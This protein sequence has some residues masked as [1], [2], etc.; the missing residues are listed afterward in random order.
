MSLE[1]GCR[2]QKHLHFLRCA[3]S[4]LLV[5]YGDTMICHEI[6]LDQIAH[7]HAKRAVTVGNSA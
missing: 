3:H 7:I 5:A 6:K 2:E 4:K 1:K